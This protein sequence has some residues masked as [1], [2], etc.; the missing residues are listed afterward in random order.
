MGE[1]TSD[2]KV[3]SKNNNKYSLSDLSVLITSYN[4]LDKAWN[5][6]RQT[7]NLSVHIHSSLVLWQQNFGWKKTKT[8]TSFPSLSVATKLSYRSQAE[9]MYSIW[10]S[11][12]GNNEHIIFLLYSFAPSS[13]LLIGIYICCF[14]AWSWSY[15]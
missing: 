2:I 9:V 14:G 7:K 10:E 4:I 5:T 6:K 11:S 12:F 1:L 15:M 13:I 3:E 8:K